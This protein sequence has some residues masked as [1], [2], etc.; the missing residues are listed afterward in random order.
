MASR[1]LTFELVGRDRSLGR[2]L[3]Q[4]SRK[5]DQ[6]ERQVRDSSR[7]TVRFS[8]SL[9]SFGGVAVK[10][11]G[12]AAVAAGGLA[13]AGAVLGLK[14][15]ANLE[16]AEI[17]FTRLLGSAKEARSFLGN[18]KSF[19]ARTPFELPGLVDAARSLVGAGTAAKDVIPILTSLG[20]ASGALGLDQER[21][22]R[23]MTAVTQIMNRGKVQAEEL[24]QIT[25]A[26][27]PVWQLLAKS[28][29]KPVPE[30]QKLMQSGKLLAKDTLP[31]LFDQ[32]RKD[33]GGGME[34][35]S[36]SLN[37]VWSTFKDT[38]SLT[39]SDALQPLLPML[40]T[41]LPEA[42]KAFQG[43]VQSVVDFVH[44]DVI[45]AFKTAQQWWKD[46]AEAVQALGEVLTSVFVPAAGDA[47]TAADKLNSSAAKVKAI[48]DVVALF[49]GYLVLAFLR[50]EEEINAVL[51]GFASLVTFAGHAI[52]ALD[53]LSG[54]T[55][56]A[57]DKLVAF[58]E[59]LKETARQELQGIKDDARKAQDAID[60]LHGKKVNITGTTSMQFTKT[61]TQGDW[62]AAREAAGRMAQGGRI[63]RGTGPT[64]DDVLL[65][66]SKGE[67]MVPARSASKPEFKAWAAAEGIPGFAL[68]G[69]IGQTGTAHTGVGKM[70]DRWGTVRLAALVKAL[71][72]GGGSAA[73][74]AFIRSTDRLPYR[75]AAAGPSAYDC[76]GLASAVLGK[77]TG[78]GG[79]HGQRYFTT[80]SIRAGILGIK[81]GLGGTLQIGVTPGMG[82]MAGRY[83]G[84]GFE[85][86]STRTGI[87]IGGAA[88]RPES[89]ARR[90]HLAR[91][92]RIDRLM[93]EQFAQLT[94]ADIG[95][96][97]GRLR[98]NG[99]VL[100]DGGW[101]MPGATVAVN[102][103]RKPERVV[104]PGEELVDYDRLGKTV[105]R[106]VDRVLRARPLTAVTYLDR[107]K[108][109]R[110]L[111]SGQLWEARR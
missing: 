35:Q 67:A 92:G 101:L 26:G 27:I 94:R 52:N 78:R 66:G 20:D 1:S 64:A 54:G 4:G 106:E 59:D 10:A 49:T 76:S 13:A 7:R 87:K 93:L 71:V 39:L 70:M 12:G 18:L 99:K 23:V 51:S 89:F 48:L 72:G 111:A 41:A 2:T 103:T 8:S 45:P 65:W 63:T 90:F 15:A 28:T 88:S 83:G 98:I 38:V 9:A 84:L 40:K 21:F 68:G 5:V 32:M 60:K 77:M 24:N 56:R 33:Y 73:I 11:F 85:A 37:G 57:G 55:G 104:G 75:W 74:K 42:G 110:S 81:P 46:N 14:T 53:R 3:Q 105:A 47:T 107:Q 62:L 50:A 102:R 58:G 34:E 80:A 6:F 108:V 95:G 31:A 91:G 30:L 86:E 36:K 19:A 69:L 29:G 100:D 61:F 25:E 109:T 22:G 79:G 96:D 97:Q 82:H 43:S 16:T 17:G 44:D